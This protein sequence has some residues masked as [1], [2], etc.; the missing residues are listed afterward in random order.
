MKLRKITFE[1]HPVFGDLEIDFTD[2]HGNT[3]NTIILAG[4]NGVGK[5]FLLNTIFEFS[6]LSLS[7][8]K[9][10]E[11][12]TFEI[13]LSN[14]E[15]EI[16]KANQKVKQYFSTIYKDNILKITIDYNISGSWNQIEVNGKTETGYSP[17]IAS[18]LF[19]HEDT[20]PV[21]RTIFSD[22]E[23]NFTPK[24]INTVTSTNIDKENSYSQRSNSN[25]ATEITQLLIDVTLP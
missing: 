24:E 23:I 22:V 5:S 18:T 25:L 13:Q 16:L 3:I 21:L 2:K 12:R 9:R 6:Y 11:K 20:R 10:D 1:K 8:E 7:G 14:S 17:K 19:T 4:E 15:V